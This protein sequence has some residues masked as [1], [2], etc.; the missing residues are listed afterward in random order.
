MTRDDLGTWQPTS[1]AAARPGSPPTSIGSDKHG[2]LEDA[3]RAPDRQFRRST[4]GPDC[5]PPNCG[6][7]ANAGAVAIR[8][9]PR[10]K[11]YCTELNKRRSEI[12]MSAVANR[13]RVEWESERSARL[14]PA[15]SP[16][17]ATTANSDRG[18][19]SEVMPHRRKAILICPGA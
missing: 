9:F 10:V 5:G 14:A 1:S 4:S 19:T 15:R 8:R 13:R 12:L 16:G 18:R 7:S 11:Y 2:L 6:R 3:M 17:C